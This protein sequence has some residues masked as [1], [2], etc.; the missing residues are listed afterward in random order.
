MKFF[1]CISNFKATTY[2]INFIL[3]CKSLILSQKNGMQLL[4][5]SNYAN[6]HYCLSDNCLFHYKLS[7]KGSY[8]GNKQQFSIRWNDPAIN[9]KWP[10]KKPILS[11]RDKNTKYL[12]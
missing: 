1:I 7:Y 5:P 8:F 9:I 6:G 11:K 4:V 12:K 10:T 2:K 3:I